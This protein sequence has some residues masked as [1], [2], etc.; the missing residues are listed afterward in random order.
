MAYNNY[1]F[2]KRK[3]RKPRMF[4]FYAFDTED[5]S[6]GNLCGIGLYDPE[7]KDFLG[8]KTA[9]QFIK[10]LNRR[11]YRECALIAHN[12]EYDIGNV[13]GKDLSQFQSYIVSGSQF[14][15]ARLRVSGNSFVHIFD[16]YNHLQMSLAK[17]GEWLNLPKMTDPGFDLP[18]EQRAEYCKRDCEITAL[19][20]E[21]LQRYY[22]ENG[23]SFRAT[24][25]SSAL[26]MYQRNYLGDLTWPALPQ[27]I[28]ALL[29]KGYYGGRTECFRLGEIQ[30]PI[31]SYDINS[32]YPY[33]MQQLKFAN[34]NTYVY[35]KDPRSSCLDYEGVSNCLAICPKNIIPVLPVRT[36]KLIFPCGEMI[37]TWPNN[38]LR[39]ALKI[40]YKIKRIF[41]TVSAR[42]SDYYL[43]EF[44]TDVY[45]RRL[46]NQR[47]KNP[48]ERVD[49]LLMNSLSGKFNQTGRVT[50]LQ[51]GKFVN[52]VKKSPVY[53]NM[54]CNSITT[55]GYEIMHPLFD[56]ATIYTDTDSI[57]SLHEYPHSKNLG[58]LKFEGKFKTGK[59]LLPKT[60]LKTNENGNPVI[61]HAKGIPGNA[62]LQ[63]FRTGK[64]VFRRPN[65]LR[66]S[67]KR[68]LKIN[69]WREVEKVIRASYDKRVILDDGKTLP[70]ETIVQGKI[71]C[72]KSSKK[73]TTPKKQTRKIQTSKVKMPREI[74]T[75]IKSFLTI[76]N[77]QGVGSKGETENG[78]T[79]K[80]ARSRQRVRNP[81]RPG[82]HGTRIGRNGVGDTERTKTSKSKD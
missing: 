10:E 57:D 32:L 4:K 38:L 30:G 45:A 29:R 48:M 76:A 59:Y 64:A 63:V 31:M 68:E 28:E 46:K 17:I 21:T 3:V 25:G 69:E 75:A 66:E 33:V 19:C 71:T 27:H 39:Y 65:R 14:K 41:W 54:W 78:K 70:L 44:V 81:K 73:K 8:F 6:K 20:A 72:L 77:A 43:R 61:V 79:Q 18:W 74:T 9:D 15:T 12:A 1:R 60:Y 55:G 42:Q 5:D 26:E 58:E 53:S 16:T 2:F 47:E 62:A 36:G 49:K 24:A 56:D 22:V 40:G 80:A 37:G 50:E 11:K 51:D 52:L 82:S 13:W 34:P 67:I 7:T 35:K 23:T